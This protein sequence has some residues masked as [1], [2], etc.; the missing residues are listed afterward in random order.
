MP[1]P[2]SS[3]NTC[4]SNDIDCYLNS[5]T[6][7]AADGSEIRLYSVA[8]DL[9]SPSNDATI[10]V[11]TDAPESLEIIETSKPYTLFLSWTNTFNTFPAFCLTLCLPD[12]ENCSLNNFRCAQ[13]SSEENVSGQWQVWINYNV[14]LEDYLDLDLLI[15]PLTSPSGKD[16][17]ETFV[18]GINAG[19]NISS[20]DVTQVIVGDTLTVNQTLGIT[21][22]D[23]SATDSS[24]IEQTE[25]ISTDNQCTY[26]SQCTGTCQ[27]T[28]A[29][30]ISG[31]DCVCSGD[32]SP[33]ICSSQGCNMSG[34]LCG[35][36]S[37]YC[38]VGYSCNNG[39]CEGYSGTCPFDPTF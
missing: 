17:I 35:D 16:P 1:D 38:C 12:D 29:C 34:G 4:A 13:S 7:Q 39:I 14:A 33:G 10:P 3:I 27:S 11:I 2:A 30:L 26:S 37:N 8:Q 21:D 25:D 15:V 22:E 5:I 20:Y 9:P 31:N 18:L 36:G 28:R 6:L 23:S 19:D 32:V 24:D